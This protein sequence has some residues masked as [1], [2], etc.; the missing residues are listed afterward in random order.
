MAVV[1]LTLLHS[2]TVD[3]NRLMFVSEN[4]ILINRLQSATGNLDSLM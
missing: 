3:L 2:A 4:S 1:K